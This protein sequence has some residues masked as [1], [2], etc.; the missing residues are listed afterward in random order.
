MLLDEVR[1][2]TAVPTVPI[3]ELRPAALGFN[4]TVVFRATSVT[5]TVTNL[6]ASSQDV[7][8]AV[9]GT[10]AGAFAVVSGLPLTDLGP[11]AVQSVVL[12]FA[13]TETRDHSAVL[14]VVVREN[15]LTTTFSVNLSGRAISAWATGV[16]TWRLY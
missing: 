9:R 11:G 6:G 10:D 1:V 14:D 2:G 15:D 12:Q 3:F 5:M 4:T 8:G 7:D 13:P 16:R